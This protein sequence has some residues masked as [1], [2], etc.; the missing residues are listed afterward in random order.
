MNF[1]TTRNNDGW[2]LNSLHCHTLTA[3]IASWGSESPVPVSTVL[4]MLWRPTISWSQSQNQKWSKSWPHLSLQLGEHCFPIALLVRA[5]WSLLY[6]DNGNTYLSQRGLPIKSIKI[7]VVTV[8]SNI[9]FKFW[10]KVLNLGRR[11]VLEGHAKGSCRIWA[12]PG[13]MNLY[14]NC[15]NS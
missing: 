12:F 15:G 3:A 6:Q 14:A 2:P 4:S 5:R 9:L 1:T 7:S 8:F 13:S 11:H 10:A